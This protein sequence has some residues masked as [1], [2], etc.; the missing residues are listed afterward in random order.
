MAAAD[1]KLGPWGEALA[2][3]F[4]RKRGYHIVATNYRSRYGEIDII[5]ENAEYLVFAE[6][7]LRRTAH[8]GAAREF[9][10]LR[11]QERLRA[12]ASMFLEEHETALQP[13]FDVIEIYAPDG[14]QTGIPT[15]GRLRMHFMKYNIVDGHC[16]TPMELYL[17][18]EDLQDNTC[19]VSLSRA[20]T[21]A[22]YVQFYAFCTVWLDK[23]TSFEQHYG[24]RSFLF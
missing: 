3:A 19:Q 9:V 20:Q 22:G 11:K 7:K 10:D 12:T 17:R 18:R 6:V 14:L 5:A 23:R 21:L 24:S 13:R 1:T 4:L 16:D 2:A 15:S 8:F